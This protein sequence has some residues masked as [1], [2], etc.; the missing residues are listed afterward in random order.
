M[1]NES[2]ISSKPGFTSKKM[3]K[4]SYKP[5]TPI[6][7]GTITRLFRTIRDLKGNVYIVGG[8]V[9]E[10]STLRDIDIVVTNIRDIP[11]IKKHLGKYK[12]MA[13]FL[14]Q[15]TEP[16]ATEFVKITGKEARS[17]DLFEPHKGKGR[18]PKNEYAYPV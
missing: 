12:A 15:K 14:V 3:A 18:Y 2:E 16:P 7:C 17:A 6:L 8:L 4:G 1:L 5:L 9:T 10:G 13:H 11:N